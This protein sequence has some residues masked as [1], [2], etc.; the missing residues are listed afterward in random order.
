MKRTILAGFAVLCVLAFAHPLHAQ[1]G[2]TKEQ[3]IH[4]LMELTGTVKVAEQL[5]DQMMTVLGED[6][7]DKEFWDSFRAQVDTKELLRLTVPIYDKHFTHEEIKGLIAFYQSPL[8]A[9]VIEKMPA[10]AQESMV[11]GMEWGQDLAEKALEKME[12]KKLKEKAK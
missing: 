7:V 12:E 5:M 9:K 2:N 11:V 8:G 6:I 3:D 1:E 4:R 10:V